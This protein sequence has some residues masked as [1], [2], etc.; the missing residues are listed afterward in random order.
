MAARLSAAAMIP[1]ANRR[2][3][4]MVSG[5]PLTPVDMD[6]RSLDD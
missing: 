1:A 4:S 5:T 2:A 3:C 6:A